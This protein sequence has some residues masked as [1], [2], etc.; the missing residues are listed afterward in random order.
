MDF[1]VVGR[2]FT[3]RAS[4]PAIRTPERYKQLEV[5]RAIAVLVVVVFH[6]YQYSRGSPGGTPAY[7]VLSS[8]DGV[9]PCFFVITAFLLFA[10]IARSVVEGQRSFSARAFLQRRAVRILPAYYVAVLVVWFSRQ[11][12][13]PGDWR[14]LLEHLTFTQVFDEKRIFYTNGPASALSV[15][16]FFYLVLVVLTAGVLV[17]GRRLAG[18]RWRV[19]SLAA[20]TAIV[21]AISLGWKAWSFAVEH[22]STTGSFT[23]WFGPAANFDAFAVGM[24]VAVIA[25]VLREP[26]TLGPRRC[27]GLRAAALAILIVAF[28]TR[29]A[30]TWPAVYFYSS[31]AVGFGC[32][33][34]ASAFGPSGDRWDRALSWRPLVAFSSLSYGIYLWHEPTMLAL[35]GL[36]GLIRPAPGSFVGDTIVVLLASTF[37]GWLS[38]YFVERPSSQLGGIFRRDGRMAVAARSRRDRVH[39]EDL[40]SGSPF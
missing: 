21:A 32:L 27:L 28:A 22:R 19:A 34:A 12:R 39:W 30:D 31:C 40:P 20:A 6:V 1:H 5:T 3:P 35:P 17:V 8:L 10:P 18:R 26:R 2:S 15:E 24:A 13:L 9:V 29:R 4:E 38:F 11:H 23:T 36:T 16:V 33:V 7:R 14:D 25:A 37:T